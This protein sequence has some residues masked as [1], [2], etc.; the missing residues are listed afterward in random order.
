MHTLRSCRRWI[1]SEHVLGA[2][3][4]CLIYKEI[5]IFIQIRKDISLIISISV[6]PLK[7][8]L[9]EISLN[10][11][12]KL[13]PSLACSHNIPY[14][15]QYNNTHYSVAAGQVGEWKASKNFTFLLSKKRKYFR[16]GKSA[17]QQPATRFT[18]FGLRRQRWCR[19]RCHIKCLIRSLATKYE[20]SMANI[21][22]QSPFCPPSLATSLSRPVAVCLS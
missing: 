7:P 18:Q 13:F 17:E 20:L 5:F 11:T 21:V 3:W 1:K 6:K 4:S 12:A 2:L 19:L 14:Q 22:C 16:Q 15:H 8:E 9:T 10:F